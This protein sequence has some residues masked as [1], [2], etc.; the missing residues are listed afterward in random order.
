M[1]NKNLPSFSIKKSIETSG[2]FSMTVLNL[3]MEI[4]ID[5]YDIVFACIFADLGFNQDNG[6][7]LIRGGESPPF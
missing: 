7:S 1:P 3:S 4:I 5:P 2:V 6:I